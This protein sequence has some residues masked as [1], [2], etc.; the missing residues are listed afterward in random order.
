LRR[1]RAPARRR[2]A[3]IAR[4]A[5]SNASPP[6]P[7]PRATSQLQ[8]WIVPRLGADP[9]APVLLFPDQNR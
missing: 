5:S 1:A 7:G 8:V 2:P 3:A 9:A 6:A 4:P